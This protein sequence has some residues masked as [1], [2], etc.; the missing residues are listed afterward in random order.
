MGKYGVSSF[1]KI[2]TITSV[3]STGMVLVLLG[4]VDQ[5]ADPRGLREEDTEI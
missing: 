5:L 4:A 3:I 1:W 2:Q